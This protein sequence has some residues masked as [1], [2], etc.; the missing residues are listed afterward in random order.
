MQDNIN[1]ITCGVDVG[2]SSHYFYA[3]DQND[4]VICNKLVKQD[5][6]EIRKKLS[7]LKQKGELSIIVDVHRSYGSYLVKIVL[8]MGIDCYVLPPYKMCQLSKLYPGESKTDKIDAKC[9]ALAKL[10]NP[11]ILTKVNKKKIESEVIAT[12]TGELQDLQSEKVRAINQLRTFLNGYFP[13]LESHLKGEEISRIKTLKIISKFGVYKKYQRTK[14]ETVLEYAKKKKLR[15]AQKTVDLFYDNLSKQRL[16]DVSFQWAEKAI[17][18]KAERILEI[19]QQMKQIGKEIARL[20][21]D[22]ETAQN[23]LS[24]PG[25]GIKTAAVVISEVDID[26][27][28]TQAQ[29][30]SYSGLAPRTRQSGT[31]LNQTHASRGGN[32]RLKGILYQAASST[33]LRTD[34]WQYMKYKHMRNSGKTHAQA[35]KSLARKMCKTLYAI[36]KNGQRYNPE[37]TEK[38]LKRELELAKA[39]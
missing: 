14:K 1:Y 13:M 34:S 22:N 7:E 27:F 25:F 38:R 12:L 29:F 9:L 11:D 4:K 10:K 26:N 20:L 39:S 18:R 5:E 31:S 35:I 24:I 28:Q 3:V 16:Y 15:L 8:D 2:K 17:V 19:I 36:M 30:G 33:I 21:E 6:T 37:M 32:K 23:I